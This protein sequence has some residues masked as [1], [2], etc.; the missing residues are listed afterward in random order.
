MNKG[1]RNPEFNRRARFVFGNPARMFLENRE[2]F[3]RVRNRL[4]TQKT[5]LH[6]SNLPARMRDKTGDGATG[7]FRHAF[8][9]QRVERFL[10]P[11]D[12]RPAALQ[13]RLH[14]L[15][16]PLRPPRRAH[17]VEQFL[18]LSGQMAPLTPAA[19]RVLLRRSTDLPHQATQR[20][21]Q[22]ADI[23]RVMHVRLDHERITPPA[24][25]LAR[26][27]WLPCGRSPPPRAPPLRRQ[28]RHVVDYCLVLVMC[29]V[30]GITVA[31]ERAYRI[32]MVRQFMKT[33]EVAAQPLLQDP[34]HQDLPQVHS[35]TANR[36]GRPPGRTC[37][38]SSA[39][40]RARSASSHRMC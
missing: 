35:R 39:N 14:P 30:T 18:D 1:D 26:L 5:P 13:I 33:V 17:V 16:M 11:F 10:R 6:M 31:Q 40:S 34:Q 24:Q 27:F 25:W 9:P 38:S 29:L 21:P 7:E 19:H 12:Q 8:V 3:L 2:D 4:P 28:Q 23:R 15:R 32:V 36:A 37:S 20:V 22:Q